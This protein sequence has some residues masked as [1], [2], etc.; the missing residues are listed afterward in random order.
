MY[1][2]VFSNK[3]GIY[4][5]KKILER[6]LTEKNLTVSLYNDNRGHSILS[7]SSLSA[8]AIRP[9]SGQSSY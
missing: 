2:E 1:I 5:T 6:Q 3:L 7:Y 9:H 4:I 8:E